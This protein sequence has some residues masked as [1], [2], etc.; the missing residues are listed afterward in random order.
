[1]K[2]LIFV[3]LGNICRSPLA[4]GVARRIA[5]E[6]GIEVEIDSAGTGNWHVGEAP[7]DNSVR[8]ARKNGIDI[9]AQ[10][11]RQVTAADLARFDLVIALDGKNYED[12]SRMG[13]K[14]LV[15]L[16]SFGCNNE[17]VP[18]PYFFPGYEGFDKVFSMV[19]S[20]VGE[21]FATHFPEN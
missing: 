10:R 2:S 15:K 4:E 11:A 12:L 6:R 8:V 20:C 3:C 16:G 14:Q 19:E 17:D 1:M 13:A 5:T 9:S 18:D 7:C 21:L